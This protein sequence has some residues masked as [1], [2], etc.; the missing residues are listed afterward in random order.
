[1][2]LYLFQIPFDFF[3]AKRLSRVF[4]NVSPPTSGIKHICNLN[5]PKPRGR[6]LE[7]KN[8][9]TQ[10][11]AHCKI[12]EIT[13]LRR[14]KDWYISSAKFQSLFSFDQNIFG[15][16][17]FWHW[18]KEKNRRKSNNYFLDRKTKENQNPE[19]WSHSSREN[20]HL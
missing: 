18:L 5:I 19:T 8:S 6:V 3:W 4:Q 15:S 20:C 10:K 17:Q 16:V 7:K 12:S 2:I 13:F 9:L 14:T 11:S 1:M